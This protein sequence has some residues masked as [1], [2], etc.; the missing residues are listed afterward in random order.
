[1]FRAD[2]E[3]W[4]DNWYAFPWGR[5][6]LLLSALDSHVGETSLSLM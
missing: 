3:Y 4:I 1:M 2:P 5:L 6:F